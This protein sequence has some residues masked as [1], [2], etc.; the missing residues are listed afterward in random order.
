[1]DITEIE[2]LAKQEL[3]E[4]ETR[5]LIVQMKN[6]LKHEKK[7]SL[8]DRLI[9]FRIVKKTRSENYYKDVLEK[10]IKYFKDNNMYYA[11]GSI[12]KILKGEM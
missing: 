5:S 11:A 8:I 9:P 4:E 1:M 10:T 2:K 7:R 3:E 6:E 12:V